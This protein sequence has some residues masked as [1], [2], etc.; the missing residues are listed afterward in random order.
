[1]FRILYSL[2]LYL[3]TPVILLRLWRR[4]R[5]A[6]AYRQRWAERFGFYSKETI[7]P[8]AP[9]WIHSVSVGE[10]IA[11]AP[12]V[13]HLLSEY[14]HTPVLMTTMTPTGS[15]RVV[16]M[17]GDRVTHVYCPYDLPD[18]LR[19]FHRFFKPRA[20]VIVETEL[21]PNL[22]HSCANNNVPVLVA[23]AR[24][25]ARSARGYQRFS[26]LTRPMLEAVTTIAA[27]NPVDGERFISLGLAKDKL[28]IT[29]S[30]KFDIELDQDKLSLGERLRLQWG[31]QRPVWVA[32][33]THDDEH[34]QILAI[35]K[36]LLEQ[37]P[38]LVLVLVPRHP[39]QF[40]IA[41]DLAKETGLKV[42][43]RSTGEE[44]DTGTQVFIGDTLGEMLGFCAAADIVFVGG[45]LIERGGHNP[46]EPALLSR[47]VLVGPYYFN[48]QQI[49][50]QLEAAGALDVLPD[51]TALQKR[52]SELLSDLPQAQEMG[53]NG[54]AY[55]DENRGA[56]A[57]LLALVTAL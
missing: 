53:A 5:Q 52:L 43:R 7:V 13:E 11:I 33:S 44:T 2:I 46:L 50:D 37:F 32:A 22:I 25:S 18:T 40:S 28:K 9:L 29:G 54:K 24:L 41:G 14:P 17:F 31:E 36:A 51:E 42:C 57:R 21:W 19:R 16:S 10:T 45:S 12:F 35:H 20:C 27:Q 39:E 55:L 34:R 38:T 47:P 23:N 15:E 4:G 8:E 49:T 1:M 6:P 3:L 26:W 48:F 30:I 56:L